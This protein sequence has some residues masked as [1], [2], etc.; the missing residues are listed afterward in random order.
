MENK[1]ELREQFLA[2]VERI[3]NCGNVEEFTVAGIRSELRD[4]LHELREVPR[5]PQPCSA[6]SAGDSEMKH[7]DHKFAGGGELRAPRQSEADQVSYPCGCKAS[8]GSPS[9][10]PEHG[11]GELRAEAWRER[12]SFPLDIPMVKR[13]TGRTI[14]DMT[15]REHVC[16]WQNSVSSN[17]ARQSEADSRVMSAVD[18]YLSDDKWRLLLAAGDIDSECKF[19]EAYAAELREHSRTGPA[20]YGRTLEEL[21]ESNLCGHQNLFIYVTPGVPEEMRCA[22]C[23]SV[24]FRSG[25]PEPAKEMSQ[26]QT[27]QRRLKDRSVHF[28]NSDIGSPMLKEEG[29]QPGPAKAASPHPSKRRP[30]RTTTPPL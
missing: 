8:A 19:A 30:L 10:C 21:W 25:Q 18:F 13:A 28:E 6:C 9:Y 1:G 4:A 29:E 15:K 5:Q 16:E 24:A 12:N 27:L 20:K 17:Q 11:Q 7:H 23:D 3:A 22:M 2:A 14:P 26:R